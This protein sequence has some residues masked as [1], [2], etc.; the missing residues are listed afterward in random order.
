MDL[1]EL[2]EEVRE[3]RAR[4]HLEARRGTAA[5]AA[6]SQGPVFTIDLFVRGRRPLALLEKDGEEPS[7]VAIIVVDVIVDR[8]ILSLRATAFEVCESCWVWV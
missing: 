5:A 7:V 3:L 6:W 4:C 1:V 2:A 8:L